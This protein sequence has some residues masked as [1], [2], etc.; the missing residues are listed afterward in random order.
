MSEQTAPRIDG[1]GS[2]VHLTA[3]GVSLVLDASGPG[4]PSVV[5]WGAALAHGVDES[6]ALLAAPR[7]DNL[8]DEPVGFSL[9]PEAYTG[10]FGAPGLQGVRDDRTGW[11]TRFALRSLT[12]QDGGVRIAAHDQDAALSM[13][14]TIDLTESGVIRLDAEL[15]NDGD[16]DYLLTEFAPG[17]TL[18]AAATEV[19]DLTGRW[20]LERVPQRHAFTVG[21]HRRETRRG[22]TGAETPLVLLVGEQG[23]GFA[24]GQVWGVH[25]GWSGNGAYTAERTPEGH[26]RLSA[27]ELLTEGEAVLAPGD[28]Y[29]AP[30]QF[31]SWGYGLD[32]LSARYHRFVRA[33][34]EHVA[35]PRPITL[36]VWEAVY[37]EQS[38]DKLVALADVAAEIGVERFVLDDGWFGGRRDSTRGLGDWFVSPEVWPRGLT[39]LVEHVRRL[40]MQFGIWVEPEMVNPDSDVAREHP[41]WILRAGPGLPPESRHQQALDL[42]DPGCFD[43]VRGCLVDLISGN[44]VS[45]LKWDHNRDLI[46]AGDGAGR[47]AVHAQTRAA[48]RL[49]S[50][51]KAVFPGLEI[52]SCSSGGAR[53]DLGVLAH[54]D[55][56]WASDTIDPLERQGIQR[57]TSLLLPPELVGSHIGDERSHTTG[58]VHTQAFRAITTVFSHAG[59]ELDLTRIDA[60]GRESLAGWITILKDVRALIARGRLVRRELAD[61]AL[62]VTGSVDDD[63][64]FTVAC[65]RRA[66]EAPGGRIPLPGLD[67]AAR[68]R[69]EV[70]GARP[71]IRGDEVSWWREG[72]IATGEA[73][74]VIGLP[75][76]QIQPEQAVLLRATRLP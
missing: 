34:E 64:V 10:W 16:G 46:E 48:Y 20:S 41:E 24:A 62:W 60:P 19:H 61:G 1:A 8:I 54:A 56:V 38:L 51:L 59:L 71:E 39:P 2:V 25:L 33:R 26:R 7:I 44:D 75:F 37:F 43:Y 11:S 58:R 76:P 65:L 73:L 53:V 52:E 50:E 6:T 14:L 63:A 45:Y 28:V 69:I 18:P 17:L 70:Q 31:F 32:E 55:R 49:M 13:L 68:Y 67:P 9:V 42:A 4:L 74:G 35:A 30:S 23:H 5:H 72:V 27:A 15:R 29:S 22:R 57:W 36:N 21:R 47:P 3:G 40:G 66:L 12:R